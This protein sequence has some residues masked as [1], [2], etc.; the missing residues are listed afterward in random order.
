MKKIIIALLL[1]G[2]ICVNSFAQGYDII[3]A[4]EEVNFNHNE[5]YLGVGTVSGIGLIVGGAGLVV[6]GLFEGL[7]KKAS[8]KNNSTETNEAAEQ[9]S[10]KSNEIMFGAVA[11]YNYYFNQ[12]FGVG[13]YASYEIFDLYKCFTLQAK[14]TAQYGW[15]HFKIYQSLSAGIMMAGDKPN[16]IGD[17]TYLGLKVDFDNW[18]V[19]VD[20]SIQTT[21]LVKVGASY[22]F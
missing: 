3:E 14:V 9:E 17:L 7:S 18:N 2:T 10:S 11:G 19:F 13:A 21:S 16:F 15:E 5:V 6:K 8:S 20:F 22:K 12:N 4:G 1:L